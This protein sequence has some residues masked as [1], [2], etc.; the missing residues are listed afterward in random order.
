M[1]VKIFNISGK[2]NNIAKSTAIL[3]V[4]AFSAI[5]AVSQSGGGGY[6][7]AFMLRESGARAIALNGAY[8]AIANDPT[9][10]FYNP[11]GLSDLSDR[12][13]FSSMFSILQNNRTQSMLC[14][15]QKVA[16]N[17]GVGFGI[18]SFTSGSFS[19]RDIRGNQI[20]NI[21]ALNYSIN[22][23]VAYS[24]EFASFGATAKYFAN[25]LQG[26]STT[27]DGFA[28]DLGAKFNILNMFS[29]GLALQNIGSYSSWNTKTE[30]EN[31]LPYTIR[32]GVAMEFALNANEYSSRSTVTG[33]EETSVQPATRYVLVDLDA[34]FIQF[35]KT[36]TLS[37][38]VEVIP[39]EIIAFRAGLDLWGE[40][41]GANK[42]LP[43]NNW[44]AGVSIRPR[45][46]ELPFIA[47]IDYA[48][49]S[50]Y[51]ADKKIF[52]SISLHFEL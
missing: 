51:L 2:L 3:F 50:D 6:T 42:L 1:E 47:H 16:D 25:T 52:H 36:P 26:A 37:V 20:K 15:G 12:P 22:G 13:N 29:F 7:G 14:W 43:M 44:G 5:N 19:S 4:F 21:S 23:S 31:Y 46:P 33:E 30:E 48:I 38:G 49:G 18:N 39:H 11:A 40:D 45:I 27:G 32:A 10:L 28:V 24:M 8:T 41:M 9:A 17:L 35:Q 34:K